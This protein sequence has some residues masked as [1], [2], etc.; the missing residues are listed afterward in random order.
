VQHAAFPAVLTADVAAGGE[1]WIKWVIFLS[2][3]HALLVVKAVL[4]VV[5]PDESEDV[6]EHLQRNVSTTR[7]ATAPS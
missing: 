5:V 3:E 7:A 4:A 1:R 2:I 6:A